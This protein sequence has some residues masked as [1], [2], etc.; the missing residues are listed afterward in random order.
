MG[1]W[2]RIRLLF[3]MKAG[4][5][6]DRAE[7]PEQVLDYAYQQQQELVRKVK[8]G[9]VE[10][11]TSKHRLEQQAQKLGA[12]VPQLEDQAKRA[13]GANREDLARVAIE[14][15]QTALGALEGL[16]RQLSEVTAEEQRL[17]AAQLQ[18]A[19][20][21]EDFRTRRD[22]MSARYS[23][24]EVQVKVSEALTGVSGE[25]AEISMAIGRAEEKTERMQARAIA[26]DSLIEG[27]APPAARR[28]WR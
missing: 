16:E 2:S 13:L 1:L 6:L 23:A 17:S 15:K 22:V 11:A 26:I 10:V 14:R 8:Q 25:F 12:R 9:L 24:S 21:V 7:N 18:L 4:A 20:R 19:G 3:R 28:R 27:G 5:A